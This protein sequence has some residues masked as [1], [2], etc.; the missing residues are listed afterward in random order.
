MT[1]AQRKS[2]H[3]VFRGDSGARPRPNRGAMAVYEGWMLSRARQREGIAFGAV[4]HALG[5][6]LIDLLEIEDSI[7]VSEQI[8]N[9]YLEAVRGLRPTARILRRYYRDQYGRRHGQRTRT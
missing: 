1:Q 8:G 5:V 2:Q 6:T 3:V 7:I 4:A 9:R